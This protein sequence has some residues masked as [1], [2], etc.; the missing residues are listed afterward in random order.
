MIK[1]KTI[2]LISGFSFLFCIVFQSIAVVTPKWTAELDKPIQWQKVTSLGYHIVYCSGILCGLDTETG[3]V[4][5]TIENLNG[6][7]LEGLE[8][9]QNSPY[10]VATLA[11]NAP[12]IVIIDP[13]EGKKIFSSKKAGFISISQ[14]L[15]LYKTG[16]ILVTGKKTDNKNA[17]AMIDMQ[18]GKLLWEL[19]KIDKLYK[20]YE[21]DNDD[22]LLVSLWSVYRIKVKTGSIVWKNA[23]SKGAE[24][25]NN[26]GKIGSLLKKVTDKAASNVKME[27][28]FFLNPDK[29]SFILG[30]EQEGASTRTTSSGAK[31]TKSTS[32]GAG[33]EYSN[34]YMAY[35]LA[36]GS[37]L[38]D[39]ENTYPGKIGKV[40]FNNTG[41][42]ILPNN[43][44]SSL[45]NCLKHEDGQPLWGKR[46]KGN[47]IK[48]G[49]IDAIAIEDGVMILTMKK[50]RTYLNILDKNNGVMK[51]EKEARI[52]GHLKIAQKVP[53][54]LLVVTNEELNIFDVSSGAQKLDKNIAVEPGMYQVKNS[55]MY[56]WSNRENVLKGINLEKGTTKIFFSSKL[57]FEG[58]EKPTALELIPQGYL[59]KSSQNIALISIDGKLIYQSYFEAPK[60]PTILRALNMARAVTAS[61][62]AANAAFAT[63]ALGSAT[64]KTEEES[65]E[66]AV[67]AGFTTVYSEIAKGY[68]SVAADSFKK[69][70]AR[71]K[72]TKQGKDFVFILTKEARK[73]NQIVQV[74]K[75]T[76]E[77]KDAID[78]GRERMPSYEV[79][80]VTNTIFYKTS[81][82][83]I[84]CYKF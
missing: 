57:K 43:G 9:I 32:S 8:E 18:T 64:A 60:D 27:V 24:K 29:K 42:V 49:V 48:G 28:Q 53:A 75:S 3:N 46:G 15:S 4:K 58:K 39:I 83:Q 56:I 14:K 44:S 2:M 13:V 21:I 45:I 1:S 55:K 47:K 82:K 35:S 62:Y 51:W 40:V 34:G 31:I 50:D 41:V 22:L 78:L 65:L 67:G 38:W 77:V 76:G 37:R 81:E 70:N 84:K 33:P 12:D 5:W 52:D 36:D 30:I 11:G 59:L 10:I 61:L 68:T 23:N 20:A 80:D 72:A 19:D 6:L 16:G 71:Y 66:R 74:L 54:G 69:A 79:D 73:N 25:I 7:N 26:M 17:A 63:A